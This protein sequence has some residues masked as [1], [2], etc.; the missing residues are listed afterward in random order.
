[1]KPQPALNWLVPPIALFT[2]LAAAAGLFWPAGGGGP[3]TFTT[4]HGQTIQMYGSGLYHFD[5]LMK[6]AT[7]RGS[8]AITLLV[9]VPLLLVAFL[10]YRRGK[11]RGLLLLVGALTYALYNAASLALGAAY[12]P[13]LLL[14]I[15]TF[16]LSLFAFILAFCAVDLVVLPSHVLPG[17]PYRGLSIFMLVSG[18]ILLLVW[19][20]GLL[21]ALF[22]GQPIP[23]LESYTTEVTYVL[24]LGII[25]PVLI[26][27]GLL[28]RRRLPVSLV[29]SASM[30]TLCMLIGLVVI[31]QTIFQ[32]IVGIFLNPGQ[33]IGMVGSFVIL[34]LVALWLSVRYF[35]NLA[36]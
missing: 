23:T 5:S 25:T 7:L 18:A 1:M 11:L 15:V 31:G 26:L 36:D 3:F 9:G 19:M 33:M 2:L 30:L 35:R 10:L 4:L 21:G 17:M 14:Y 34:S 13:L 22:S 29:L 12:N 8:D 20:S 28:L 16:S 6:G 24:D 32:R 27:T